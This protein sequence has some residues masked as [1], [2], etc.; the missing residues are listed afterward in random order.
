MYRADTLELTDREFPEA[1]PRVGELGVFC[2]QSNLRGIAVPG[3]FE[4]SLCDQ[5]RA[6]LVIVCERSL[7]VKKCGNGVHAFLK[8]A[9]YLVYEM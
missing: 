9:L 3:I 5:S 8:M 2:M 1:C 6:K 4:A 7:E